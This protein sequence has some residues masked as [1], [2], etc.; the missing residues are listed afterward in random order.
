MHY[1]GDY[2]YEAKASLRWYRMV[3]VYQGTQGATAKV[4]KEPAKQARLQD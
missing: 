2:G 1:K 3:P 4:N